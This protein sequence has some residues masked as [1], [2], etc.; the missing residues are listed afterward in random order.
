VV[1]NIHNGKRWRYAIHGEDLDGWDREE[2]E[3]E[4]FGH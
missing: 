2:I 3:G 4:D 1:Y